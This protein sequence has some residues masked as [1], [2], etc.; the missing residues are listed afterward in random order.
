MSGSFAC[1]MIQGQFILI[2]I[3]HRLSCQAIRPRWWFRA[4]L[5]WGEKRHEVKMVI[6]ADISILA[7]LG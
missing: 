7:S 4:S 5:G 3:V 1:R 6:S 2:A